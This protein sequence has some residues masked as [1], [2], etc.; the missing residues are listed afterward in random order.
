M[1]LYLSCGLSRENCPKARE[2][3]IDIIHCFTHE[4]LPNCTLLSNV[5]HDIC[6]ISKGLQ[7]EFPFEQY[8]CC[9]HCYSLYDIEVAP[10]YCTY[11][12]NASRKPCDAE[13]FHLFKLYPLPRLQPS[14]KKTYS[15]KSMSKNWSN[16]I[17]GPVTST[18]YS[19]KILF[20][21]VLEWIQWFLNTQ[22]IE[23]DV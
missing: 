12:P 21:K 13:R 9:P 20:S 1:W 10:E 14:P 2:M 7:L 19:S 4:G 15:E 6:T 22:G 17:E 16:S 23:K 5:P 3:L 8:V 11:K 18:Y